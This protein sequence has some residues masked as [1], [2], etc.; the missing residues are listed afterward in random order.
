MTEDLK[1]YLFSVAEAFVDGSFILDVVPLGNG[2]INDTYLV[3]LRN[4]GREDFVLQKISSKVFKDPESIISNMQVSLDHIQLKLLSDAGNI[5]ERNWR[6]TS[7][8]KSRYN[9]KYWHRNQ[10][11][12]WRATS[13]I[14]A[15]YTTDLV[16]NSDDAEEVGIGL[17][18]FHSLMDG[19]PLKKLIKTLDSF[20]VTPKYHQEYQKVSNMCVTDLCDKTQW[21]IDF[22]K[23]REPIIDVLENAI[24]SGELC[25][26]V[27]HGDP[28]V[29]NFLFDNITNKTVAMVDL[30]TLM[31]G[32]IHYDLGDCLRSACNPAGEEELDLSKVFF[33]ID[34]CKRLLNG[35]LSK[36]KKL[37]NEAD[38]NYLYDAIRLIPFELGMRFFSDY[39]AGNIYF[40]VNHSSHN[41]ERALVQFSLT[42]SIETQEFEIRQCIEE[43]R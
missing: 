41:L 20:H 14:S 7:L 38:Y 17:G 31:T 1:G 23:E 35:Y 25:L 40:K 42:K 9:N 43:L 2:N 3:K 19:L 5:E 27:I 24:C 18:I 22:I 10:D 33:C 34:S 12:F 28:K 36:T 32:L 4:C 21:C 37:L 39:L 15:A 8:L 11:E 26:R 30:D 29:N 6:S 16:R 13:Y